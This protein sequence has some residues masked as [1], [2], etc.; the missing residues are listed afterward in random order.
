MKKSNHR[1]RAENKLVLDEHTQAVLAFMQENVPTAKLI[2]TANAV[3]QVARLL[4]ANYPQEPF[5][6][7]WLEPKPLSL[8]TP[9]GTQ[10]A[11][12]E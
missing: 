3:S 12:T 8:N 5:T 6:A 4:W 9:C 1:D 11:A 10:L 2:G 7:A